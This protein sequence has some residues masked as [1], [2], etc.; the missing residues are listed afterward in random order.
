M[1]GHDDTARQRRD[2]IEALEEKP[3]AKALSGLISRP[4]STPCA[5]LRQRAA[6]RASMA[7]LVKGCAI[8]DDPTRL[9]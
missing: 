4:S 8:G 1:E 7:E 6:W 5:N 2:E 3:A 9:E